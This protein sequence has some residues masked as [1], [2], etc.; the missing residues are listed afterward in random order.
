MATVVAMT[1]LQ[2]DAL[3][4]EEGIRWELLDGDLIEVPS[5]TPQHQDIVFRLLSALKLYAGNRGSTRAHQNIEFALSGRDRLRPD[6]CVLLDARAQIDPRKV[7][8][9]GAPNIAVEVISPSE[10]AG[11]TRR[12]VLTYLNSGVEEV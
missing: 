10:R 5:P 6:V 3:P 7:P 1:G 9:A 4:Y 11:D 8:V 12:K 2:F